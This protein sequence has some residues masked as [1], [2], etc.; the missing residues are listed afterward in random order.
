MCDGTLFQEFHECSILRL[1]KVMQH[2]GP[3]DG[4]MPL[5]RNP[6]QV[7]DLLA[8]EIVVVGVG[9]LA[10]AADRSSLLHLFHFTDRSLAPGL[11]PQHSLDYPLCG[12]DLA[13]G[14]AVDPSLVT[15]PDPMIGSAQTSLYASR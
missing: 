7:S 15:G 10:G 8:D 3:E 5:H 9:C 12:S 2:H 6:E 1:R 11:H 14:N 4:P 13:R